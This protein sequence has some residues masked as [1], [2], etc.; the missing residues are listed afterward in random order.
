M[1]LQSQKLDALT[2]LTHLAA[3]AGAGEAES[4]QE[5]E[6]EQA[7]DEKEEEI[8]AECNLDAAEGDV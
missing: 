1:L 2:M 6:P 4:E 5:A 8:K 7:A 3:E